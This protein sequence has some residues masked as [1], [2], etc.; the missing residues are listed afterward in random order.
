MIDVMRLEEDLKSL[1]PDAGPE[2]HFQSDYELL[3]AVIL[4]AQCTD[5]RVNIITGQLFPQANTPE[6]MLS[7]GEENIREIIRSCGMYRQKAKALYHGAQMLLQEF[8][9]V[10]PGTREE[11]MRLPGVGRKTANVVLSNAF[12]VPAIAVDTHVSRLAFRLG[13]S[14]QKDPLKIEKDLQKRLP[15]SSWSLMH[16]LL[17]L[18]GRRVCTAR[19]PKCSSCLLNSYCPRKG[20]PH[21]PDKK[22]V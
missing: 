9:G 4:S 7:L 20:L 22:S 6:K 17:I 1:Y 10:I 19:S 16:H 14:R 8:D 15:K 13:L 5:V 2:L 18:H 3:V 21:V 11:L 12:G